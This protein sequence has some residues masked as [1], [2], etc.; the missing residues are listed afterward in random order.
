[1]ISTKDIQRLVKQAD[2]LFVSEERVNAEQMWA[3][4]SEFMLN[5]QSGIFFNKGGISS[6]HAIFNGTNGVTKGASKTRRVYDSTALQA[7]QDLASAFQSTLTNPATVWSKIRFQSD[8][9]N[10]SQAA[11]VWL[12]QVNDIIHRRLAESNFDTEIAKGYQS[13]VSMGNM[14][15]FHDV[16]PDS[17]SE[18]SF[19]AMH[20]AQIAWAE[21]KDSLVDSVFRNFRLTAKQAHER[22]G[23]R[24][25]E[26]I[27]KALEKSPY[28]E[29][30]FIHI[31]APRP[32]SQVKLNELGLAPAEKRPVASVYISKMG[33]KVVE[34]GGYY[35]MPVYVGRWGLLPNE[36]YGRGPGHLALPDVRTLNQVRQRGLEQLDLQV[37]PPILANQ[38]DVFGQLDLRPRGISIVRDVNGVREM[39]SQARQD[40][41]QF[42]VEDLKNSIMKM[43]FLDKLLLP[44]RNETG[45]MTAFE[46]SERIDQMHR[47]LGPVL[48]RLNS[49]LLQPLIV[50]CFKIL[51]REGA[52]P[53]LPPQVQELG[54]DV[55]IVF[56]NQLARAQQIQDLTATQQ[57]LQQVGQLAQIDPQVVDLVDVDAGARGAARTLGV[58]EAFIKEQREV[59]AIRQ[60]R[61]QQIQQAQTLEAGNM[62]ADTAVKA[63][64]ALPT[65]EE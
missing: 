14:A 9:L 60:Q 2:D 59:D 47:V 12:E 50:R 48:T 52:L 64:A 32:K 53:P 51:L 43:F 15:L 23:E 24:I 42:N 55:D 1:M 40:I 5:N 21:D 35:E 11:S 33:M 25:P 22:W 13:F 36:V 61:A 30:E 65:P 38:R 17:P 26:A 39:V 34:E 6:T 49:E 3:D 31:I 46:V 57:W 54:L 4:I 27:K 16:N 10:D 56:V 41:L 37:A 19:T 44:P 45:E 20:L 8:I 7:T 63:Q 18:F 28:Q 62:M 58:P 29:F